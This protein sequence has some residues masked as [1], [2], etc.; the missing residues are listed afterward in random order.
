MRVLGS[1][2]L[3]LALATP[4]LAD[5]AATTPIQPANPSAAVQPP[6]PIVEPSAIT[7]PAKAAGTDTPSTATPADHPR[8]GHQQ[9]LDRF[10]RANLSHNG[11]LTLE[12]AESGYKTVARHFHDI[13]VDNKGYVT[14][15]DIRAWRALQKANHAHRG[16]CDD[17]LHPRPAFDVHPAEPRH[18]LNA[19]TTQTLASAAAGRSDAQIQ[20]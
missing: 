19:S 14:E 20:K 5:D 3:L 11:H 1:F 4:A 12:E 15:N 16:K 13:D 8:H 6:S 7:P 10:A 17:P 9:R 18:P 2:A